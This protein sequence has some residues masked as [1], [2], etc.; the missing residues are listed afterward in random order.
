MRVGVDV[1]SFIFLLHFSLLTFLLCN[2]TS[3]PVVLVSCMFNTDYMSLTTF[4]F[5]YIVMKTS[6][7]AF[8][9]SRSFL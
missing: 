7:V 4:F 3:L 9:L 5:L 8:S 6:E 1:T 2:F